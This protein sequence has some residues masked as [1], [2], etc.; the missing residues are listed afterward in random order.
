MTTYAAPDTRAD[1]PEIE[2]QLRVLIVDDAASTRRFL[3]TVL[4]YAPQFDVVGEAD[5][6]GTAI[7]LTEALQPDVVLLDLSMPVVDGASA[8][9][10]LL[11]A[12]PSTRVIVLTGTSKNAAAALLVAGAT[13]FVTKGLAPFELLEQL[14]SILGQPVRFK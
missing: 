4:E 12:A 9:S 14:G 7:E 3:R 5:N 2:S 1:I 10:G 13:A 11:L 6:G 8:L